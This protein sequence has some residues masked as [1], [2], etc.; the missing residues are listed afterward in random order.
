MTELA[1]KKVIIPDYGTV[2]QHG[3]TYY[4]TRINDY[5]G[6]RI[7]LYGTTKEEL[8]K[9][10]CD[11]E[12][13]INERIYRRQNPTVQEYCE[14]W[15]LMQSVHI[16]ATTLIDYTSKVKNYIIK[17]LGYMYMADVR[18]DDIKLALVPVA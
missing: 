16:R 2:E 11:M 15:L 8:Y 1:R 7:T 12:D 5:T 18:S 13:D 4:R 14:Q 3:H 10:V 6:K 9:K 17:P